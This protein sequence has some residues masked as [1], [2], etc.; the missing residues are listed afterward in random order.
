MRDHYGILTTS[1][2]ALSGPHLLKLA[3][4]ITKPHQQF[5]QDLAIQ[6]P[7]AGY[8]ASPM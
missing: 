8:L 7:L 5:Q 3:F 6:R 2:Q 1:S 4:A